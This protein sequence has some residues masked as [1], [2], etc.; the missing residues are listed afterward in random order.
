MMVL[1]HIKR[2][3]VLDK[4]DCDYEEFIKNIHGGHYGVIN[5]EGQLIRGKN[6]SCVWRIVKNKKAG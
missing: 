1:W 3:E 2:K 4:L 5:E 6:N